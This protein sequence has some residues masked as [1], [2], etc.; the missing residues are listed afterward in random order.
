VH[1]INGN[2]SRENNMRTIFLK[3]GYVVSD[4]VMVCKKEMVIKVTKK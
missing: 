2:Q 4:R 3:T 1:A